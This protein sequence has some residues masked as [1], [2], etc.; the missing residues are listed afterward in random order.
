MKLKINGFENEIVFAQENINILE[1]KD[2]QCFSHIIEILNEKINGFDSDEIFLLDESENELNMSKEMYMVFDLFN[3]DYNSKKIINKIYEIISD[4]IAKNQDYEIE[5]MTTKL[6][7][8]IIQEINELPFEFEMKSELDI[9][10]ILKL[11][12]LKIDSSNYTTILER[13][14]LLIDIISTLGI[15]RILVIPNLKTYLTEKELV[16][17][18][19]YALYNNVKLLLI[20]RNN[21]NK[22]KYEEILSIDEEFND[23]II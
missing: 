4:N 5:N 13:V 3:I 7:N 22:L 23:T 21:I 9:P 20:E 19:K 2:S 1:I 11:Y 10:E 18:Y 6:R 12:N 8:Y 14:E 15:A 17:L 16:E